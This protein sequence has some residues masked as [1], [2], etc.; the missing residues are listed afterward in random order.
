MSER[1]S[2]NDDA[3][4]RRT[5]TKILNAVTAARNS[6][7]EKKRKFKN[8]ELVFPYTERE[9]FIDNLLVRIHCCFWWTSLAP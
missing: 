3:L 6:I 4:R 7:G 5:N 1:L 2:A 8:I 9:F